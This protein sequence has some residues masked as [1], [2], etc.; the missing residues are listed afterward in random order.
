MRSIRSPNKTNTTVPYIGKTVT[1]SASLSSFIQWVCNKSILNDIL[2]YLNENYY[3]LFLIIIIWDTSISW[4]I[5]FFVEQ[6]MGTTG[7][8]LTVML[9]LYFQVCFDNDKQFSKEQLSLRSAFQI[10]VWKG[11]IVLGHQKWHK[12]PAPFTRKSHRIPCN[13][14]RID[15]PSEAWLW[16]VPNPSC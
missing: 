12:P 7:I 8:Y 15:E 6:L 2:N 3:Q 14:V 10:T 1:L 4:I 16:E 11:Q 9:F 13:R 5:F